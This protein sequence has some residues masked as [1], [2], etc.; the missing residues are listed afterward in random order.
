VEPDGDT[1][2]RRISVPFKTMERHGWLQELLEL[3]KT[4]PEQVLS[5]QL[6]SLE[7]LF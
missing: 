6:S 4:K 1:I 2:H 7:F 3:E 5:E